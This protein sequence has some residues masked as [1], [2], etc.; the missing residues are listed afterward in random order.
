MDHGLLLSKLLKNLAKFMAIAEYDSVL[1]RTCS[2]LSG[3]RIAS[4]TDWSQGC[5]AE[6]I[7]SCNKSEFGFVKHTDVEFYGYDKGYFHQ[8]STLKGCEE[9]C[10]KLCD[11]KGF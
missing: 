1:G 3:Y 2:C 9:E 5:V 4:K 11:C 10:L 6:F 8:F 7:D